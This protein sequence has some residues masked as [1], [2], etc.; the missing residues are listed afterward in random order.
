MFKIL[1]MSLLF[2][3]SC[4]SNPKISENKIFKSIFEN[5]PHAT[6]V[7]SD[8]NQIISFN[9][10]RANKRFVPASTFKIANSLIALDLK[11][12]DN[13]QDIFY[14]YQG[15]EVFLDIWTNSM[16]LNDAFKTSNVPAFQQLARE[17]GE[18][19]YQQYLKKFQY[20]N[21]QVGSNIERFWLDGPL[22]ISAL[23]QVLFLQK[24]VDKK[25]PVD[26]EIISQ[27]YTI[28]FQGEL[29]GEQNSKLYGKTGWSQDIG[30]YIG[31]VSVSNKNYVFALNMDIEKFENLP[32]REELAKKA[33]LKI[34]RD[35]K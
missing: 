11:E 32:L 13:D 2:L 22:K 28:A 27:L 14:H 9:E 24:I 4:V 29:D 7:V 8:G 19:Q 6:F 3:S 21:Q 5:Y 31:W 33:L 17:I 1:L 10:N 34:I 26:S 25:L 15:G 23:E 16:N 30:W 35:E 20:G 18:K 12:I